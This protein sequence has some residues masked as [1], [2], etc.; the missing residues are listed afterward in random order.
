MQRRRN[1]TRP[2]EVADRSHSG[3]TIMNAIRFQKEEE[4][5]LEKA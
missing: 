4:D 5:K 1:R 3:P 2:A